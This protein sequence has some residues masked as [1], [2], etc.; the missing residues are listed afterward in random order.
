[1]IC[2]SGVLP[3]Q[4]MDGLSENVLFMTQSQYFVSSPCSHPTI[5]PPFFRELTSTHSNATRLRLITMFVYTLT[6]IGACTVHL[7]TAFGHF[8]GVIFFYFIHR[9]GTWW[10]KKGFVCAR[11]LG[12]LSLSL[13]V[14]ECSFLGY[15]STCPVCTCMHF[16]IS[17]TTYKSC[18]HL[19]TNSGTLVFM[20]YRE[21]VNHEPKKKGSCNGWVVQDVIYCSLLLLP[22]VKEF[23]I[24]IP[25]CFE[26]RPQW[27][28]AAVWPCK[29]ASS[30]VSK[31]Y[32]L[33]TIHRPYSSF[34]PALAAHGEFFSAL[35][36]SKI[37]ARSGASSYIILTSCSLSAGRT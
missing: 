25:H 15:H 24:R 21:R 13:C 12:S 20:I 35:V 7:N 8:G 36:G 29:M 30:I 34:V 27:S 5:I 16:L 11:A 17:P 33:I 14:Y 18:M 22:P 37:K 26:G 3:R 2:E 6:R 19:I 4:G 31:R 9:R 28:W 10:K 32:Q 23:R 1:M